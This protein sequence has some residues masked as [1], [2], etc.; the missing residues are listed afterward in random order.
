MR[1]LSLFCS[2][3]LVWVDA[4]GK[5]SSESAKNL[6]TKCWEVLQKSAHFGISVLLSFRNICITFLAQRNPASEFRDEGSERTQVAVFL[7]IVW[8]KGMYTSE[9]F[10]WLNWPLSF[11]RHV[12]VHLI[13]QTQVLKWNKLDVASNK[14]SVCVQNWNEANVAVFCS[15][16]SVL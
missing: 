16:S 13:C 2:W 1:H 7:P 9:N 15:S 3:P 8:I 4:P 11:N 14:L 5:S 6:L 10:K 12:S